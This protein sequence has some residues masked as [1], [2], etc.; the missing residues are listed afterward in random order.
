MC[1]CCVTLVFPL[2]SC[3]ILGRIEGGKVSPF[4]NTRFE[5]YLFD[6]FLLSTSLLRDC[7]FY[8]WE[9]SFRMLDSTACC[10]ILQLNLIED[11]D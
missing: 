10:T 5:E 11:L 1:V 7:V 9:A 8:R 4:K 6:F 2:E 3:V